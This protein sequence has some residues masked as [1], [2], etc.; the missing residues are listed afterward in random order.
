VEARDSFSVRSEDYAS[1]RPQY[2]PELFAWI[3][4]ECP[5]HEV[6]WD[7]ATG[8]GQAAVGL[9]HHFGR[10]EATDISP[11]QIEHAFAAPNIRY[12]VQPAEQ[13]EFP[14]AT[15]DAIVVAQ[16]LH[17]FDF[18]RFWG[19]VRRVAK[20]GA[21]FCAWGY[22]R[23][24]CDEALESGFFVPLLQLLASYWAPQNRIMWSGYRSD[25]IRFPF[26]RT[27]TPPFAIEVEWNTETIIGHV[28]TWS[29]YKRAKYDP[30][31]AS[32]IS[33]LERNAIDRFGFDRAFRLASPLQMVAARIE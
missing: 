32:A 28:R 7:C 27:R 24:E 9:A 8:N 12:S 16:A 33:R 17:W 23:F 4:S 14:P 15:F 3:V 29:A 13:T 5:G 1:N 10:I 22:D 26:R 6:A 20:P 19:E 25:E 30:Q 21:F 31:I 18:D 2:P 11:Q